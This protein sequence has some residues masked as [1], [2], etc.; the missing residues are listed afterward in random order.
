MLN[1]FR[2]LL[3][4]IFAGAF[5]AASL[6]LFLRF[7]PADV[8][9]WLVLAGLIGLSALISIAAYR[10]FAVSSGPGAQQD[11]RGGD[12][13]MSGLGFG[14]GGRRSDDLDSSDPF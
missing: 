4:L 10:W 9:G 3:G 11:D 5:F 12:G 2:R 7:E 6:A 13:Y 14:A 8:V 1:F